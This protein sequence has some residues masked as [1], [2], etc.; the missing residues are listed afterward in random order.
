MV[1]KRIERVLGGR[2]HLDAEPVKQRPR[3]ELRL[4]QAFGDPVVVCVGGLRA[5]WLVQVEKLLEGEVQPQPGRCAAEQMVVFGKAAPD[6]AHVRLGRPSIERQYSERLVGDSLADQHAQD[7]MVGPDQQRGR[8]G[9][10]RVGCK[11]LGIAMPVRADDR[12]ATDAA[13]DLACDRPGCRIGGKKPVGV[14]KAH[15][16]NPAQMG[17][18]RSSGR[19][20]RAPGPVR[21]VDRSDQLDRGDAVAKRHNIFAPA[22]KRIGNSL[23]IAGKALPP[24]GR[25]T[26]DGVDLRLP[27]GI[28]GGE[29][30]LVL[31]RRVGKPPAFGGHVLVDKPQAGRVVPLRRA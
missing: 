6:R 13:M 26:G 11:P 4:C 27:V 16:F 18:A 12:Q 10:R 3:P 29:C 8:I 28:A 15:G 25:R 9:E 23:E 7:V 1:V 2:Q 19:L 24:F 5:K 17:S 20:T 14:Q 21:M 31:A 30:P 22:V